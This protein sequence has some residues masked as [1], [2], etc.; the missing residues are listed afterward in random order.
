MKVYVKNVNIKLRK[1]ILNISVAFCDRSGEKMNFGTNLERIRKERK[2]SQ[3]EL[4]K[5]LGLT[6][7]VV[8]GYETGKCYPNLEA[9][10]KIADIFQV[11]I[12]TLVGHVVQSPDIDSAQA[13]LLCYYENLTELDKEKCI[14]IVKTILED[15]ELSQQK[16]FKLK[17]K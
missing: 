3:A 15:R 9:V 6:Q 1:L 10:G 14:M 12:D 17:K 13:R 16:K 2:I 11:S 4:A 8:S 5:E 7:Q